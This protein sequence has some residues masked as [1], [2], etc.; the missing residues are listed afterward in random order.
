[1]MTQ[2]ST[3]KSIFGNRQDGFGRQPPITWVNF[4]VFVWQTKTDCN[5]N[6]SGS[7]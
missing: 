3:D 4:D 1:M 7:N 6:I 2:I 5:E